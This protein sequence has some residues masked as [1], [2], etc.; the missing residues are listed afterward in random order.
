MHSARCNCKL[1]VA[2]HGAE[3]SR[4]NFSTTIAPLNGTEKGLHFK[5]VFPNTPPVS[6]WSSKEI[7]PVQ[8]HTIGWLILKL[9]NVVIT[10]R[11]S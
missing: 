7:V 3:T 11:F 10:K 5:Q 1:K 8:A 2:V 9:S 6:H 4:S